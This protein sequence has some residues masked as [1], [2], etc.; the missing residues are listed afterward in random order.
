MAD[1]VEANAGSGGAIFAADDIAGVHYPRVKCM[2]GAD[3]SANEVSVATPMPVVQTGALPAGANDIGDVGI[4]SIAPGD[5]NIGNVDVVTLPALPAGTNNIGDVDVLSLPALAAGTNNIGDVDVAS[6]AAGAIT[7]IQGDVADDA[8]I[9][10]NP[11]TIGLHART[12]DRTAVA[13][14]D[15]VRALGDTQ[16]K[17]VVLQGAVHELHVDDRAVLTTDVAANIINAPGAT[18]RVAV[19]SILVI[20]GHATVSTK[21]EIRRGTTVKLQ[22]FAA[23][24]GGGF[25]Y[26]AGG[27]PLFFGAEN[28]AI[29]ARCTVTG[30]NVDVFVSGY[31][32]P[33]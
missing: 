23:A 10:G 21:V 5:N 13:T 18:R 22:G 20:N 19:Q 33:S 26:N 11:V 24:N 8:A 9:A 16:G 6:F 30:S 14:G 4:L 31:T 29:T 1:N 17:Q 25:S 3:G 12:A 28:E 2:W 15:A 32:I 7:E 27:A